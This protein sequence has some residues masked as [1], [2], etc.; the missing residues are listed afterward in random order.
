MTNVK[1]RSL[2]A[3]LSL[4]LLIAAGCGGGGGSSSDKDVAT[5]LVV[6]QTLPTNRQEVNRDLSD[7]GLDN[8][9]RVYFSERVL[10]ATVIDPT[11][12]FNYL[13]SDVNFL[14]SAMERMEGIATLTDADK[15]LVFQPA[16]FLP[17]GQYTLTCTRDV[18]HYQ[19]GR[20]NQGRTDFRSSFTVG[21]DIF[22][23]V[24]RNTYPAPNQKDI[25]KDSQI[26]LTFNE[27]LNVSTVTTGTISVVDGSA[28][29]PV[30]ISGSLST[31][32]NAFEVIFTPDP[33]TGMPPNAT[34]VVTITGGNN[35]L[36]DVVGNPYEGH[37]DTPGT[38]TFQFETVKEPP[39]PNNPISID[40]VNFDALLI[41]A[42]A[43]NIYSL[44]E[45][46]F[47]GNV[48][49]MTLWGQNNPI[50][51]SQQRIGSPGE[52]IFDPRFNPSDAHT[53]IYV[54]DRDSRSVTVVGSRD[55]KIVHRWK[56]LPDPRGL[57]VLPNGLTLYVTN[58]AN[59]SVSFLDIGSITAGAAM[60]TDRMK[61]LSSLSSRLDL[62]VGNGPIGAACAPD[63]GLLF[64]GNSIDNTCTLINTGT[65]T[66][67][68]TFAIGTHPQ[69]VAATF[70]F[71]GIGRF[72]FITCLGGGTDDNGSVS[73]YWNVP[74]GLQ[75]TVTGFENPKGCIYDRGSSIWVAN[76][77]GNSSTQLTLQIAGG[78]FAATILPA[79]TANITVGASP[80]GITMESFYPYFN[81][82]S[83]TIISACRGA[84][85]LVFLDNTQPSRPTYSITA[86]GVQE[87]A[88]YFDQ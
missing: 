46:A 26:I 71:P 83:R 3:G 35:G 72:A 73:L 58:Y 63:A 61:A 2:V 11:N 24:L 48:A 41:Y 39:P 1:M 86:P 85:K 4:L 25:P 5:N 55:S 43:A 67:N 82:A 12:T 33:G 62:Q 37:I 69:D 60:A 51:N 16:G 19:G 47:L 10:P 74:N 59:G 13:T 64:V 49:D 32:L 22:A 76:S 79:I 77:G 7:P 52:I 18:M 80:T 8:M 27:S 34:I 45:A 66:I 56:D 75:A 14:N 40:T 6:M 31:D 50:A 15:T 28:N 21:E 70:N 17:N 44:Q 29:P 42:D 78:G 84:G 20:L 87:I 65:A 9:I 23:P 38:Y 57:A 30:T 68:T 53:Y 36:A 88:S 54:I 81:A